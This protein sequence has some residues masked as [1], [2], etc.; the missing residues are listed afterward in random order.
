MPQFPEPLAGGLRTRPSADRRLRKDERN[1]PPRLDR[2][3]NFP[4]SLYHVIAFVDH[5][6]GISSGVFGS[7]FIQRSS[8][9]LFPADKSRVMGI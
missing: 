2:V 1:P 5:F 4:A 6:E 9:R 3:Q 7:K 8:R